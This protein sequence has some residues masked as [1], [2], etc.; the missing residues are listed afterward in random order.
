MQVRVEISDHVVACPRRVETSLRLVSSFDLANRPGELRQIVK[1]SR[2]EYLSCC[3]EFIRI[4]AAVGFSA[5]QKSG[6]AIP[7]Q[8]LF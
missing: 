1:S 8:P 6:W 7:P 4:S 2:L 3:A 5:E